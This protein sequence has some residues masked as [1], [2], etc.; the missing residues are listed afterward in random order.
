M[1]NFELEAQEQKGE[2]VDDGEETNSLANTSIYG[3]LNEPEDVES[4]YN[5][6][7]KTRKEREIEKSD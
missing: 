7:H 2:A 6:Y 3:H 1:G 5:F 4:F